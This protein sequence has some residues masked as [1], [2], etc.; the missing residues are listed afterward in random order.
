MP[1]V[2]TVERDTAPTVEKHST[3]FVE[4]KGMG[5]PDTIC[6]RA[7]EELSVALSRY[8]IENYGRILHHNLDKCVLVGGQS[9]ARFG[10]GEVLSPLPSPRGK[11]AS[12]RERWAGGRS[13]WG[14]S[15]SRPPRGGSGTPSR[16]WTLRASWWWTTALGRA[17]ATLWGT[18]TPPRSSVA[19]TRTSESHSPPITETETLVLE[20]EQ[21]LNSRKFKALYPAVG[22]D[23]KVMGLR[24]KDKIKLTVA[25]AIVS[26]EVDG[27]ADYVSMKKE[28]V[29]KIKENA[30]K[31]TKRDVLVDLN[32]ADDPAKGVFYLTVT[33]LSA[34]Q[35]DDG[36]VGRGNR[37]NGR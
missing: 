32:A 1:G 2:L 10:G 19:T 29:G 30:A 27:P 17:A 14:R 35:G 22:A 26:K 15:S 21:L 9:N 4:R 34:E 36:Q 3:E 5:H 33:G 6:D 28:V 31:F 23:V 11:G 24:R 16:P 25:A 37:A 8:Y 12:Q 7:S 13:P 18:T 20:T